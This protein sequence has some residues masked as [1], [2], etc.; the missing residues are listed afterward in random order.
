MKLV[1]Y[2]ARIGGGS[3][4]A[5]HKE[6][7]KPQCSAIMDSASIADQLEGGQKPRDGFYVN[8]NKP[9]GPSLRLQSLCALAIFFE[10]FPLYSSQNVHEMVITI[11]ERLLLAFVNGS[12]YFQKDILDLCVHRTTWT[13]RQSG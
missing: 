9:V 13:T 3:G 10:E 6:K 12:G 11:A 2:R 5:I 7:K 4:R 8:C 1:L